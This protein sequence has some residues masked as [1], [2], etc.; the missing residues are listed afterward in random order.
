MLRLP[1]R[2]QYIQPYV[3]QIH[4]TQSVSTWDATMHLDI[5][6]SWNYFPR[7][8][9]DDLIKVETRRPDNTLF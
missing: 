1:H 7:G 5:D 6:S 8:P 4:I 9:E 2:F 3:F